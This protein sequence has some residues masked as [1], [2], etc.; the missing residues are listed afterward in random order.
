MSQPVIVNV[1]GPTSLKVQFSLI[2]SSDESPITFSGLVQLQSEKYQ[3]Q[4]D[5]KICLIEFFKNLDQFYFFVSGRYI[6]L[7]LPFFFIFKTLL[8]TLL[9]FHSFT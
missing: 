5:F 6:K 2:L 3:T 4:F 7:S 9:N 8:Q 1:T